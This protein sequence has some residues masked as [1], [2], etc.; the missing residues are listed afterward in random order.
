MYA[1]PPRITAEVLTRLPENL[2]RSGSQSDFLDN[3]LRGAPMGSFLEGPSFDREGNL[4]CVDVAH[5]RVFRIDMQT[6]EWTV[7]ADYD[8]EPNGLK[9]HRDGRAF[10]TDR[11]NGLMVLDPSTGKVEPF[12]LRDEHMQRFKGV[13]DLY[14]DREGGIWFTDQGASGLTRPDG[15]V[16]KL[17]PNG[18]LTRILEGVP[19]PN[20]LLLNI[21]ETVLF[22]AVTRDNAVWRAP[23]LV[24]GEAAKVGKFIQM[25][26]GNG[27]DGMAQGTNGE[28]AVCHAGLGSVWVFDP[29]GEPILRIEAP[30]GLKTT[31]LAFGGA[32]RKTLFITES[33]T[34]SIL[35]ANVDVVGHPLFSH[36]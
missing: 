21:E 16:Y 7:V 15:C 2:D 31:N 18:H 26:G 6:L 12:M 4:W 1:A 19:S 17:S 9:I 11:K 20:G 5:G 29:K 28:L 30:K 14:F 13:N 36:G 24:T 23:L 8:G 35:K 27:P 32:D 10:I 22:V 3:H 25:S 33:G 34:G